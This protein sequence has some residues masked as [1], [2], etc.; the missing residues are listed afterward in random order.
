[1]SR[2]LAQII[3]Q[4]EKQ[5]FEYIDLLQKKLEALSDSVADM[6][7]DPI[8]QLGEASKNI[9]ESVD[10]IGGLIQG[11]VDKVVK[12]ASSTV[13]DQTSKV[14]DTTSA[15]AKTLMAR[16][17]TAAGV[18]IGAFGTNVGQRLIRSMVLFTVD[19]KM[20]LTA[21]SEWATVLAVDTTNTISLF[22]S[23]RFNSAIGIL[24]NLGKAIQKGSLL[25]AGA[26]LGKFLFLA[27]KSTVLFMGLKMALGE[28]KVLL[29]SVLGKN[30]LNTMQKVVGIIDVMHI[31]KT[32]GFGLATIF[33]PMGNLI[34][35]IAMLNSAIENIF[36]ALR[37]RRLK[38]LA[39]FGS[40]KAQTGLLLISIKDS[41]QKLI[42][43]A[44]EFIKTSAKAFQSTYK[45]AK[46]ADKLLK[47]GKWDKIKD[48][49]TALKAISDTKF[50]IGK[51]IQILMGE[52]KPFI[53]SITK[54]IKM[55][56]GIMIAGFK[57]SEESIK[58]IEGDATTGLDSVIV[59]GEALSGLV[60]DGVAKVGWFKRSILA[61]SGFFK[62]MWTK[63]RSVKWIDSMIIKSGNLAKSVVG[64]VAQFAKNE[65][66]DIFYGL[67]NNL[68]GLLGT[69]VGFFKAT[70]STIKG[71]FGFG[72][73]PSA[74][75]TSK[76]GE[77]GNKI[78]SLDNKR[79]EVEKKKLGVEQEVIKVEKK[80]TSVALVEVTTRKAL[81]QSLA[82]QDAM[83]RALR[84]GLQGLTDASKVAAIY[85]LAVAG[86]NKIQA[87]SLRPPM[88]IEPVKTRSKGKDALPT[89]TR[90]IVLRTTSEMITKAKSRLRIEEKIRRSVAGTVAYF[91]SMGQSVSI[92]TVIRAFRTSEHILLA[93]NKGLK[94]SNTQFK[95]LRS[96]INDIMKQ[97]INV[98]RIQ[99]NILKLN[100]DIIKTSSDKPAW[101]RQG[102][103]IKAK[104]ESLARY[105]G[106]N[107]KRKLKGGG[108]LKGIVSELRKGT[109]EAVDQAA[110]SAALIAGAIAEY[111][112]RSPAKKGPLRGLRKSGTKIVKYLS[113]GMLAGSDTVKKSTWKIA[114]LIANFFP[115][116]M[117]K[118]GPLVNIV[119][120]GAKIAYYLAKGMVMGSIHLYRVVEA[121]AEKINSTFKEAVDFSI[122]S[123]KMNISVENLSML[124]H[125]LKK[126]KASVQDLTMVMRTANEVIGKANTAQDLSIFEKVGIDLA[127]VRSSA[128]PSL[129]I[130]LQLSDAMKKFGTDS[131][132]VRAAMGKL[133]VYAG[134]NLVLALKEGRDSIVDLM[135]EAGKMGLVYDTQMAKVAR[136][137]EHTRETLSDF[138]KFSMV[139]FLSPLMGVFE[140]VGKKVESLISDNA[141]KI[142]AY[143]DYAGRVV[144]A[145]ARLAVSV[146]QDALADPSQ[147]LFNLVNIVKATLGL[148]YD[149]VIDKI[150]KIGPAIWNKTKD[151]MLGVT[152]TLI[153]S[154]YL[155]SMIVYDTIGDTLSSIADDLLK[156]IDMI[157]K[158]MLNAAMW[159]INKIRKAMGKK[160]YWSY[161]EE[162]KSL[163]ETKGFKDF[164]KNR[165]KEES[166]KSI[167]EAYNR[168]LGDKRSLKYDKKIN[169]LFGEDM[170]AKIS[171]KLDSETGT[172]AKGY[173][174]LAEAFRSATS[175]K[176]TKK[177]ADD[178]MRTMF[179]FGK[180]EK[181]ETAGVKAYKSIGVEIKKLQD[182]PDTKVKILDPKSIEE[183]IRKYEDAIIKTLKSKAEEL[184]LIAE[185][186]GYKEKYDAELAALKAKNAKEL[187]EY[188]ILNQLKSEEDEK[189]KERKDLLEGREKRLQT[190]YEQEEKARFYAKMEAMASMAGQSAGIIN[191]VYEMT[192]KK[193]K[194]LF[195]TN[196]ALQIAQATM[197]VSVGMTKALDQGGIAGIAMAAIVG[198]AGAIQIAK[199]ATQ[200]APGFATGGLV[201]GSDKGTDKLTARLTA[202]EFVLPPDAVKF[203]GQDVL[204]GMRKKMLPLTNFNM[205]LPSMPNFEAPK[206]NFA[207]GGIV[208]GEKAG[209]FSKTETE[210]K[211]TIVNVVDPVSQL[212][213]G[214]AKRSGQDVL[215]NSI[216]QNKDVIRDIILRS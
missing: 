151:I 85:L 17:L 144:A 95:L 148:I 26:G 149:I 187:E 212:Q 131:K 42:P 62:S 208:R 118:V 207:T 84:L 105:Y 7:F 138:K 123:E 166:L 107:K 78:V 11:T 117:P 196:K 67:K 70:F 203:Y 65:A 15:S 5:G 81:N 183:D 13:T 115:R 174:K 97:E 38:L 49:S 90:D 135:G 14:A 154:L 204:E 74:S 43:V 126:S 201:E 56:V 83:Y 16:G 35:G 50:P 19:F 160:E 136:S 94:E 30:T 10:K 165:P 37:V 130:V 80:K 89:T 57:L 162:Q 72:K 125:A 134:S 163:Y 171:G 158:K 205:S 159:G 153:A 145:F 9:V 185:G 48:G 164:A 189:Y 52:L 92:R 216:G 8:K 28:V 104:L 34:F 75:A 79:L 178:L 33:A 82:Q 167:K 39:F 137:F 173:D 102:D 99:K 188:R 40:A 113:E 31:G 22:V 46:E 124:Q 112:P 211:I 27:S 194:E 103:S 45:T 53:I 111:F 146:F 120:S 157:V 128:E 181:F 47:D 100:K 51:Q 25:G 77:T 1:M 177:K 108:L 66:L 152:K 184:K 63:L 155:A 96:I 132:E 180:I 156:W 190:K 176:E 193:S 71:L 186:G 147:F 209:D 206:S 133:G 73:K 91:E 20:G 106:T 200:E 127:K 141:T 142:H 18:A 139:S 3:L 23:E 214:L 150:S 68:L 213:Q 32:V 109:E 44:T 36:T 114:N 98:E 12:Q 60:R 172:V 195:Y 161:S 24:F 122:M 215:I 21:L 88:R 4:V 55:L 197:N 210:T 93:L 143:L 2:N 59:R 175:S 198:A 64:G 54:D 199:I 41:M 110:L 6:S 87:Q 116:S 129:E 202:G 101:D 169:S 182:D 119:K 121:I 192:G 69:F 140:K 191:D 58:K 61:I 86:G 179:D 170:V 168:D 76:G 29:H